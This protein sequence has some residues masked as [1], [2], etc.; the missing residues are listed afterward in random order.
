MSKC[1]LP[2][3]WHLFKISSEIQRMFSFPCTFIG[4]AFIALTLQGIKEG[5]EGVGGR[6]CF[7]KYIQVYFHSSH[8]L[9]WKGWQTT[10]H[11]SPI[12]NL[13]SLLMETTGTG[14]YTFARI[15][16]CGPNPAEL[17]LPERWWMFLVWTS[18]FFFNIIIWMVILN[19]THSWVHNALFA[20]KTGLALDCL[21]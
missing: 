16:A 12:W 9:G 18:K 7:E 2:P 6:I 8:Y 13:D 3:N 4:L 17:N 15:R 20:L 21:P 10:K 19:P 11:C 5:G 1:Q 14:N